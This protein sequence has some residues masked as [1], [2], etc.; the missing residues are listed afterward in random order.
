MIQ[1][2]E[3]AVQLQEVQAVI[4]TLWNLPSPLDYT[5]TY[6][7]HC[8]QVAFPLVERFVR[9]QCE[10]AFG[11]NYQTAVP[12]AEKKIELPDTAQA[13]VKH[14]ISQ[15]N[16]S[17][18]AETVISYSTL[19]MNWISD[20]DNN[21]WSLTATLAQHQNSSRLFDL[22]LKRG[23]EYRDPLGVVIRRERESSHQAARFF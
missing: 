2:V 3:R 21:T 13:T 15:D 7:E 8:R 16:G 5:D 17:G 6:Q 23:G 20:V 18:L 1:S 10:K 14:R 4:T 12:E 11:P 22:T 9:E 19:Q